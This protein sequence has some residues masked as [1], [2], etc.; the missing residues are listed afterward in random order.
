[1][2]VLW[3]VQT[4]LTVIEVFAAFWCAGQVSGERVSGYRKW[5]LTVGAVLLGCLTVVQRTIAMYSRGWL[6]LSILFC[7]ILCLVC[8][9]KRKKEIMLI[10]ALYFETLY[11][12]D[13]FFH[14]AFA[15]ICSD[16]D[17]YMRQFHIGIMRIEV[18]ISARVIMTVFLL[19]FYRKRKGIAYLFSV[20]KGL[21]LV[22]LGME[23][24]S[25]MVCDP[26]FVMGMEERGMNG[27]KFMLPAFSILFTFASLYFTICRYRLLYVQAKD[28]NA[29]YAMRYEI[30]EKESKERDRIYHDFRNHLLVLQKMV[31]EDDTAKA[32]IYLGNLLQV[33]I[34]EENPRV[35]HLVLDYLLQVKVSEAWSKNIQVEEIYEGELTAL[36]PE[37]LSDWCV[38][39][40]N[41]WDNA[42]EGCRRVEESRKIFFSIKC[43]GTAVAIIMKNSCIPNLDLH[44]LITSKKDKGVHGI[45][46]QNIEY[47]VGKYDGVLKRN[48][49][50]GILETSII[51]I[52]GRRC[53]K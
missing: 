37:E 28:Q 50:E 14:I 42:I 6:I 41:L 17:F 40:G 4:V 26:V 27:W 48:K 25:L 8:C 20:G 44:R 52:F 43:K 33:E 12:L 23:H 49:K 19:L 13:V 16:Y 35:K 51:I 36:N 47:V 11:C 5:V 2:T 10:Y 31:H 24:L 45:G 21:W 3:C 18:Y 29:L 34:K 22:I 1:M 38:L 30:L 39:L 15:I 32:K 7:I 9:R 46:L 53:N